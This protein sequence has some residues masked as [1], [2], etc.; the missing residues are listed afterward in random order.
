M[1]DVACTRDMTPDAM[2]GHN[3]GIAKVV[4]L[5][6]SFI[7]TSGSQREGREKGR[8][9]SFELPPIQTNNPES[10]RPRSFQALE[11]ERLFGVAIVNSDGK[12]VPVRY[13]RE[14]HVREDLGDIPYSARL[15]VA[16]QATTLDVRPAPG[17]RNAED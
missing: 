15:A 4:N 16:D 12:K 1:A 8:A 6:K 2:E 17:R 9:L 13:V 10:T 3:T 7:F 14:Q 11:A 5:C